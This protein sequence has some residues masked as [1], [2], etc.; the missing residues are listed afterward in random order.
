MRLWICVLGV[1]L[2]LAGPVLAQ[3]GTRIALVVGNG[4]YR[5]V[6]RLAN[7]ARDAA[8]MAEVLRGLGFRVQLL[9]DAT[10]P[11]LEQAL[12]RFAREATGA[13]VAAFFFAGHGIEVRGEN[14]LI[15]VEARLADL[16]DV[17]FETVGLPA[18]LRA[19]QGAQA[20]LLIL[21]ACRDNPFAPRMR[22]LGGTRSAVRAGLAR[23]DAPDL[24]TL[25]AFATAPGTVAADGTGPNSPFT[26]A[27]KRHLPEPGLEVRQ[28]MTRVRRTVV[29]ATGGRQVPWDNSSLVADVVLRPGAAALSA[30][31]PV[32]ASLPP[33]RGT[34]GWPAARRL[35]AERGISLPPVI[36]A[37]DPREA[38]RLRDYLGAWA[39]ERLNRTGRYAMV[40]VLSVE[41]AEGTARVLMGT[42]ESPLP[43]PG[44]NMRPWHGRFLA[45]ASAAELAWEAPWAYRLVLTGPGTARLIGRSPP[46]VTPPVNVSA[47]LRRIE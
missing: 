36:P 26:A 40:I 39:G 23:M 17:D 8:D 19:M 46:S 29:E 21:D 7:P 18:V 37:P 16:A 2:G 43:G 38:G 14:H 24:G 3:P 22:G 28:V 41:E 27:L 35:A 42:S 11:A 1:L 47:T 45:R 4:A 20:R 33:R 32:A 30:P 31:A 12:Q 25:I 15:P 6:P 9:R 13:E 44:V 5:E 34:E 10:R